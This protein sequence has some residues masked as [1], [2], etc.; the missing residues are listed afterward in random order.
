MH[1]VVQ[2]AVLKQYIPKRKFRFPGHQMDEYDFSSWA[3]LAMEAAKET[4][5]VTKVA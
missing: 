3:S 2:F 4:K 1:N 5:F